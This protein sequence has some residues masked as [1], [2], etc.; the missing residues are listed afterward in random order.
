MPA[1]SGGREGYTGP[2]PPSPRRGSPAGGEQSPGAAHGQTDGLV[3]SPFGQMR[4]LRRVGSTHPPVVESDEPPPRSPRRRNHTD[5]TSPPGAADARRH[6]GTPSRGSDDS[7]PATPTRRHR[8]AGSVDATDAAHP[9]P[10]REPPQGEGHA[11]LRAA[12][13]ASADAAGAAPAEHPAIPVPPTPTYKQRIAQPPQ[14]LRRGPRAAAPTQRVRGESFIEECD[15]PPALRG[16]KRAPSMLHSAGDW[17]LPPQKPEDAGRYAVVLDLDETLIWA[18]E[19][20]LYARPGLPELFAMLDARAEPIVWTAGLRGYAQAVLANV[21]KRGAVRHCI[22]RHKKWF[23]GQAGYQKNLSLLGRPLDKV[24]IIENTPDC[25]RGNQNNGVL[26][27]DYEGGDFPD[28]TITVLQLFLTQL[29]DSGEP[30]QRFLPRCPL[31]SRRRVITDLGDAVDVFCLDAHGGQPRPG[32]QMRVNRDLSPE[33]RARALRAASGAAPAAPS[34]GGGPPSPRQPQQPAAQQPQQ[35][36][37]ARRGS[38][39]T[40]GVVC[41]QGNI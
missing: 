12:R 17:M 15:R 21:D 34:P 33:E 39:A 6:S 41:E 29:I 11:R 1:G 14:P 4:G 32:M 19:G 9:G 31:L 22:Y 5:P 7:P 16:R 30:V 36:R 10:S 26:V 3:P 35:R 28:N 18:R 20:P 24:V 23:S 27:A 2:V 37:A 40:S 13:R 8:R 38:G 25:I